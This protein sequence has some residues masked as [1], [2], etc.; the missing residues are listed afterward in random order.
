MPKNQL[1]FSMK[2][3]P[4]AKICTAKGRLADRNHRLTKFEYI[5]YIPCMHCCSTYM[6]SAT[7]VKR[8]LIDN[9]GG[10]NGTNENS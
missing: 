10:T 8:G 9:F 1:D 5:M 7:Y 6:S 2:N 4:L 3:N